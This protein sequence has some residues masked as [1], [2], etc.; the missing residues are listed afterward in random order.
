MNNR[1]PDEIAEHSLLRSKRWLVLAHWIRRLNRL[2]PDKLQ[3]TA[4]KLSA[5]DPKFKRED[6]VV[7]YIAISVAAL[8]VIG[9]LGM[10]G[11]ASSYSFY[12]FWMLI[13]LLTCVVFYIIEEAFFW[14]F[15]LLEA[16]QI[17]E[18]KS[19]LKYNPE[20]Y[21]KS[22]VAACLVS[23]PLTHQDLCNLRQAAG[24]K[25]EAIKNSNKAKKE[26]PPHYIEKTNQL[27]GEEI[28]SL[29]DQYRLQ[30]HTVA[31]AD[32]KKEPSPRRL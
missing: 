13:A 10:W 15:Q 24:K 22:H 8:I 2:V 7:S 1:T 19:F 17:K 31:V 5:Y 11:M 26:K 9:V 3:F 29:V 6:Q 27:L 25:A 14:R 12:V 21:W 20:Q 18:V 32:E 28:G 30:N 23:H 16:S 4:R